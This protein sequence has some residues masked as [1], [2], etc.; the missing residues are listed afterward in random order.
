M[1]DDNSTDFEKITDF[2][3]LYKAYVKSRTGS[4]HATSKAKFQSCAIDGLYQIKRLL[5]TKKYEVSGYQKFTIY[6]PKE[7]VIEAGSFKDKIVQHS[8]CGNVLLPLLKDEFIQT[9][10]A[11]Q[12]NKGTLYGLDCL[13]EQMLLAYNRYG[14]DCW[15]IKADIKKYFYNIDHNIL[16]DIVQA[17]VKD[18]DVWWLCEKFV[19][20][21][22]GIGLP[23][24]NQ[25]TQVFALLYLSG[26]DHFVTGELGVKYYGRYM[27]DFYLIVES[28]EYAKWCLNAITEFVHSLG[29]E[30][31]GKTQIIPFK[32]GI[33]FCG[34][35]TYVIKDGKCI[36][37]LTNEKKRAAKKRYKKMA[38]FVIKGKLSRERF[39]ESYNAWRNHILHGNCVKLGHEMDE[40]INGI[41]MGLN[42]DLM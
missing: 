9:N 38:G 14:Y 16:K 32:N 19:G 3:N 28:K 39:D 42:Q 34:F 29:L 37:K 41:F 27:D 2:G 26:L 36:R 24:G 20:N 1:I 33:K 10:Y 35:H 6:E 17:F 4:G 30:L 23:L 8:L 31:N 22:E 12:L 7:R 25:A 40:Y 21:T 18:E 15:I 11:G 13:S 5:E